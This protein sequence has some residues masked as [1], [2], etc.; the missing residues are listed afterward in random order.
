MVERLKFL[1]K[2]PKLRL[3]SDAALIVAS[4]LLLPAWAALAAGAIAYLYPALG[5]PRLALSYASALALLVYHGEYLTPALALLVAWPLMTLL[6]GVKR[7]VVIE[8]WAY[9]PI[10]L[11]LAFSLS[12][13]YSEGGISAPLFA[14]VVY[15]VTREGF[16]VM[17]EGERREKVN[18]AAAATAGIV[19]QIAWVAHYLDYAAPYLA[20]LLAT[21][22]VA[23]AY[24]L[25]EGMRRR[26]TP[27]VVL[28]SASA[29]ATTFVLTALSPLW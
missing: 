21:V 4:A 1:S 28:I 7:M 22:W 5:T 3:A 29:V 18:V 16:R 2:T 27:R 17:A 25:L 9:P 6:L 26:M 14:L 19:V 24:L 11:A 23:L 10:F 20:D 13:A 12:L 15:A 8:E